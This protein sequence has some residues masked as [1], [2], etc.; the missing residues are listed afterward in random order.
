MALK[1]TRCTQSAP[2]HLRGDALSPQTVV[3]GGRLK[4]C[5]CSH[6][7]R[8]WQSSSSRPHGERR[9]RWLQLVCCGNVLCR[10]H[11]AS[12]KRLRTKRLGFTKAASQK[13]S[14][15]LLPLFQLPLFQLP[16]LFLLPLASRCRAT[17]AITGAKFFSCNLLSTLLAAMCFHACSS[18]K[19]LRCRH[20]ASRP[21]PPRS[22]D[23]SLVV[24]KHLRMRE[25][26]VINTNEL[27]FRKAGTKAYGVAA[28][29]WGN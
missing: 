20:G 5:W 28:F 25:G 17:R 26:P 24:P 9:W 13:A 10:S 21:V 1:Y 6:Y 18:S 22:S 11:A 23:S 3:A 16:S 2:A 19:S 29:L 15:C 7:R 4:S 14:R 27:D 12:Q 8:R